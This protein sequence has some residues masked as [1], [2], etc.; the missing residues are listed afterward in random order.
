M[1]AYVAGC[2]AAGGYRKICTSSPGARPA[3]A[4]PGGSG[5]VRIDTF[6][7]NYDTVLSMFTGTCAAAT[8]VACSDNAIGTQVVKLASY[9]QP[10]GVG[11]YLRSHLGRVPAYD[12]AKIRRDLGIEFRPADESIRDTVTDLV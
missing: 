7:T 8:Q 11:S 1:K 4:T 2:P 10:A 12:T 3:R 9:L 5:T 6:G